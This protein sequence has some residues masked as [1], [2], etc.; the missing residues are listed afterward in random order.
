ML[1]RIDVFQE[2]PAFRAFL[3]GVQDQKLK[4][5]ASELQ[6]MLGYVELKQL[7]DAVRRAMAVFRAQHLPIEEHF[8]AVYCNIEHD[9]QRDWRLSPLAYALVL[10][11]ADPAH[12]EVA[13][14]QLRLL[15]QSLKE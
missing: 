9:L 13:R 2:N 12:P 8:K 4:Y 14:L 15:S 3:E 1:I 7:E 6:E 11:N 10:L 5:T